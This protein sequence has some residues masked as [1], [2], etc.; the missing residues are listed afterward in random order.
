MYK[1]NTMNF[2]IM[3][4]APND[5][6]CIVLVMVGMFYIGYY[7]QKRIEEEKERKIEKEYFMNEINQ[8]KLSI[9]ELK[10]KLKDQKKETVNQQTQT[11]TVKQQ[12]LFNDD[13]ETID[14]YKDII[15]EDDYTDDDYTKCYKFVYNSLDNDTDGIPK[16]IPLKIGESIHAVSYN[17]N[18]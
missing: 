6:I 14:K 7:D 17:H 13:G 12:V 10:K 4:E 8:L 11:E 1:K 18:R 15:W 5:G 3:N 9:V 2:K 16:H